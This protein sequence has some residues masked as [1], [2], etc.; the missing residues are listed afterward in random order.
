MTLLKNKVDTL[1][2]G[3]GQSGIA[4]SEHL[5]KH[6]IDHLVLEK[7]RIAEAWR[8]QRWDS[9]VTNGPRWNDRF[10]GLKMEGDA[11]GFVHHDDLADYFEKY[12][13]KIDA[14]IQTNVE[15]TQV[16]EIEGQARYK[17]ETSKG[18]VLA[19]SIVIATGPFQH[20][21]IP[22]VI[23]EDIAITQIHSQQ[24]KNPDQLPDGSVLVI[25]SGASGVQIAKELNENGRTV[26]LSVGPHTR[27]PRTYR[28]KDIIWWMGV[29]GI[30]NDT[31]PTE[32]V[33]KGFAVSGTGTVDFRELAH[34]GITL[35]GMTDKFDK[36]SG[37]LH[38]LDN[39]QQT[40]REG[41]QDYLK[42]LDAA[43]KFIAENGLQFPEDPEARN[44]ASMPDCVSNPLS[45]LN[46]Q[47]AGISTV[48]WATGFKNDY[49]WLD[50]DVT[51]EQ[52]K[53]KHN[54]GVTD[55]RGV[56]FLGLPFLT[57]RGSSFIW[58]VWHDASH[59]AHKIKVQNGYDSYLD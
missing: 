36:A 56:Y 39:L 10:P 55:A 16:S 21:V 13:E 8:S 27:P 52:G 22:P 14:P 33:V 28:G 30:W 54:Q 9:L 35:V 7:N 45:K 2:I 11:D 1:V 25:G 40:V 18:E 29:L 53:P 50:I 43:D 49:S 6:D 58:G 31:E 19:K 12:A 44:M 48:I 32:E 15:V 4:M 20:P 59:I 24:Y 3:G 5:S 17:V 41:E 46:L 51:D 42:L 37:E 38:F 23:P 57:C 26:Y 47:Q 34:D